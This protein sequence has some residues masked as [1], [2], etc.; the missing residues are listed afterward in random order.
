MSGTRDLLV[1]VAS[2]GRPANVARLIRALGETMESGGE[3]ALG[4]GDDGPTLP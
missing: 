3:L 4:L 1:I 2:R